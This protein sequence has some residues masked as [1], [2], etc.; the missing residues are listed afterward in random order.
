MPNNLSHKK[1]LF[2][3]KTLAK[4]LTTVN[5]AGTVP[6]P[7]LVLPTVNWSSLNPASVGGEKKFPCCFS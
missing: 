3:T 2:V 6:K 7:L 4:I 1:K 5:A